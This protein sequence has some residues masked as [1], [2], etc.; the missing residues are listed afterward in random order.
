MGFLLHRT[1]SR[2]GGTRHFIELRKFAS[3]LP[4][5]RRL[6]KHA[7][8]GFMQID[9]AAATISVN[10]RTPRN[11]I[12][13]WQDRLTSPIGMSYAVDAEPSVLQQVFGVLAATSLTPEK[14]QQCRAER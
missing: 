9:A 10:G 12:H 7:H 3:R 14:T 5:R 8:C 11:C 13:P 4:A 2:G 6:W 1:D